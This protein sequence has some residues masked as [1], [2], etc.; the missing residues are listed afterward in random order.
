MMG[1]QPRKRAKQDVDE[2]EEEAEEG[3]YRVNLPVK[4]VLVHYLSDKIGVPPHRRVVLEVGMV[5]GDASLLVDAQS[6]ARACQLLPPQVANP[7]V[8]A[9]WVPSII[10]KGTQP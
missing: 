1:C 5:E 7:V 10:S 2:K 3:T 4:H 8:V 9:W 6:S